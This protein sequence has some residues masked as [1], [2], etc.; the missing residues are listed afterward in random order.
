MKS[1]KLKS[2]LPKPSH[3]TPA[4]RWVVKNELGK[5]ETTGRPLHLA[6]AIRALL[7][8]ANQ[9]RVRSRQRPVPNGSIRIAG[10]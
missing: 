5:F 2:Q 7:D 10:V 1:K 9:P 8:P 4:A 6:H 3:L